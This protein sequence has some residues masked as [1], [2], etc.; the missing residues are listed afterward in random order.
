M[1]IPLL[2]GITVLVGCGG[3]G[4]GVLPADGTGG[5]GDIP[6]G[7]DPGTGGGS[8]GGT[9]G[10]PQAPAPVLLSVVPSGLNPVGVETVIEM[11]FDQPMD[12]NSFHHNGLFGL[13]SAYLGRKVLCVPNTNCETIRFVPG[14]YLD[15][16]KTYILTLKKS[17]PPDVFAVKS[18]AGVA[19]SQEVSWSFVT[20]AF[21]PDLPFDKLTLDGNG[22]DNVSNA[23]ECTSIA[24]DSS[25]GVHIVYFSESEMAAKHAYCPG[26]CTF[27]TTWTREIIDSGNEFQKL[28]RDINLAIAGDRLHVSYRDVAVQMNEPGKGILK[29]ATKSGNGAWSTVMVDDPP[30]AVGHTYIAEANG[31]VHISYRKVGL[32]IDDD[33]LGYATCASNCLN[34]ASWNK[35]EVDSGP[36]MAGPNHIVVVGDTV[37]ISYYAN[38]ELRYATCSTNCTNPTDVTANWKRMLVD[39][40][41]GLDVGTENS[42]AVDAAGGIHITY[43]DNTNKDFKYAYCASDCAGAGVWGKVAVDTQGGVGGTTQIKIEIDGTLHVSYRDDDNGDLKYATCGNDCLVS[44]N[45]SLYRI[46]GIGQVGWDTYLA[47]DASGGIHISY[48]DSGNR[49]LKYALRNP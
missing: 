30:G 35:I 18:L 38:K 40:G 21:V 24:V 20:G 10:V 33:S 12:P 46:D 11:T 7:T 31:R 9:G 3:G 27:L 13:E 23:G 47:V 43:K 41:T 44:S 26:N 49:A 6:G 28:G 22:I 2:L 32:G 8:G 5:G 42:L 25:G 36:N 48:R 19:L 45:W 17:N 4:G 15:E 1:A 14:T 29:Y 39:G 37:H 16:N 34:P